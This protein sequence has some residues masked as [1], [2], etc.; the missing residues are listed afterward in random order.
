[1]I[2][3]ATEND[4]IEVMHIYYACVYT[5]NQNGLYNWNTAYPA[6]TDVHSDILKGDIYILRENHVCLGVVCLNEDQPEEYLGLTWEYE[7]PF[8]VVHRLAVHPA[9][10][11]RKIGEKL[12]T[13]AADMAGEKGYRS[14]RLDAITVNPPAMKLYEKAGYE[15]RG[16]IHFPYQKHTFMCM[17]LKT[18]R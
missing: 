8:L 17:E 9:F 18:N 2:Y 5:M 13:F 11:N 14:I 7:S 16:I 10:R 1:M 12:M 6:Y 4:F 15:H 3:K